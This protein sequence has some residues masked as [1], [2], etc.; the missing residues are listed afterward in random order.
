MASRLKRVKTAI[1]EKENSEKL[2]ANALA[3]ARKHLTFE[4]AKERKFISSSDT[5]NNYTAAREKHIELTL[6][7]IKGKPKALKKL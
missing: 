4:E 5:E 3:A 2:S 6:A 7:Y 1:W